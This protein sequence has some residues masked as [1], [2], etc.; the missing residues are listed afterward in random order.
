MASP[1]LGGFSGPSRDLSAQCLRILPTHLASLSLFPGTEVSSLCQNGG[2]CIDSGPSH[3]CH[4][5]PGF[6]GSTCQDQV[7]PCESRP[8]QH[9]ATCVAQPNGY[10][11]QVRRS[12]GGRGQG[13]KV[14]LDMENSSLGAERAGRK[15]FHLPLT[16]NQPPSQAVLHP[17]YFLALSLPLHPQ[18]TALVQAFVAFHLNTCISLLTTNIITASTLVLLKVHPLFH[19]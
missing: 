13:D 12:R 9:G 1:H 6:Q 3:S 7:N 16:S 11:C 2:I 10:L 5:P 15:H 17:K 4:C 19:H 18:P 14:G 8:C